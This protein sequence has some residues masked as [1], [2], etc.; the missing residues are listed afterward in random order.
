MPGR[1]MAGGADAIWLTRLARRRP[2]RDEPFTFTLFQSRRH[3]RAARPRTACNDRLPER[4]RRRAGR[5]VSRRSRRSCMHRRSCGRTPAARGAGAAGSASR[6]RSSYRGDGH[7]GVSTIIDRTQVRRP[8]ASTAASRARS[9]STCSRPASTR[10][11]RR[12][13]R[14]RST[15]TCTCACRAA[16][17]TA[18]RCRG[19]RSAS[20]ATWCSGTCTIEAAE[21]DYGVVDPLH[22]RRRTGSCGC[23][24]HYAID[25][26]ATAR[27]RRYVLSTSTPSGPPT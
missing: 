18:T 9:A 26:A 10:R 15:R 25:D 23:P 16:P 20:C 24:E 7:W 6:P 22:G 5:G 8:A 11:R 4:R 3:G 14:S 13:C 19:R 17:A 2:G 1:L 12:S 27:L 21:R